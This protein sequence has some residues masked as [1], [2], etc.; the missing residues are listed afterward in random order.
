MDP[1]V[2]EKSEY[3]TLESAADCLRIVGKKERFE[4]SWRDV[5]E[6]HAFKRDIFTVDLICLAFK[7]SGKEE[8]LEVHEE[9]SGYYDMLKSLPDRLP[10]F[11]ESWFPDVAFPAFETN[12]RVV[13]RREKG[14]NKAP[15]PTST[16]AL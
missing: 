7:R 14:P 16:R 2:L 5:E 1:R 6:V 9:M 12:H 11:S 13:W 10:G 15:E 3:G 8:Y 4:I